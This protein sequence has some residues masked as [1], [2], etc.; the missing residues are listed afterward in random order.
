MRAEDAAIG[1]ALVDD[2]VLQG[3]Q[4]GGP[5][6]VG[7]Q[8]AA[9]QHV[10]VG[11]DVGRVLADPLA[12]FERRVAVVH[13]GSYGCAKG[14][15]EVLHRAALVGGQGFGRGQVQG[16]G[17]TSVRGLGA[18]QERRQDRH[19]VGQGL[20]RGGAGGDHH[21]VAVQ[22]VLRRLC[23]VGPGVFDPRGPHRRHH[24]RPN[25]VR[26]GGMTSRTRGQVLRMSDARSP[27][28]SRGETVQDRARIRAGAVSCRGSIGSVI[29][30]H[31]HRVC[32]RRDGQWD[33]GVVHACR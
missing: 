27:V 8:D 15:C 28:R 2:D 25:T 4:E 3:L 12:F 11:E 6:L 19:E 5:A 7:R 9:V 13:R 22:G 32:H 18:F 30:G 17:A 14:L 21:R 16:G 24:L 10:R 29:L 23:L 31:R 20:A 1:V 26:P 33:Q